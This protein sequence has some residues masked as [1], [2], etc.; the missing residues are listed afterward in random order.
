MD[1]DIRDKVRSPEGLLLEVAQISELAAQN[2]RA[3]ALLSIDLVGDEAW[4]WE[5]DG[6][7]ALEHLADTLDRVLRA[8]DLY[9]LLGPDRLWVL[10]SSLP[11]EAVAM[12]AGQR[13]RDLLTRGNHAI[14]CVGIATTTDAVRDASRLLATAEEARRAA[15]SVEEHISSVRLDQEAAQA[16]ETF[17]QRLRGAV[18]TNELTLYY[19]PQI[20]LIT[21]EVAGLEALLRWPQPDGSM[22]APLRIIEVAE[23]HGLIDPITRT[24][25][26]TALRHGSQ[27]R[28][29]NLP[30]RISVNLSP[31]L[32]G[33]P[34]LPDFLRQTLGTWDMPGELLMLEVTE[35]SIVKDFESTSALMERLAQIGIRFSIDDFGTG[36]SALSYLK[37]LPAHEL[38]I[39]RAFVKDLENDDGDRRLARSMID[40]AHHFDMEVVAEGVETAGI[41]E[42]LQQLGCDIG[43]GW[44]HARPMPFEQL[45]A[46]LERHRDQLNGARAAA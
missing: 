38:K 12:V 16:E 33:D 21:G 43:Q 46:W 28:H 20:N 30:T 25:L 34:A 45:I 40:L 22:I 15:W 24:A 37:H 1:Q 17:V 42:I 10:L 4:L 8:S 9:S 29:A 3:C 6:A 13:L 35:G 41:A 5:N 44:Y 31:R 36:Y 18:G 19:Q 2:R 11:S 7:E 32:L 14:A 23:R 26:N 39:D 27:L